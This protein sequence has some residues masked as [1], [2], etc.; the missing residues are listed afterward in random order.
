MDSSSLT[1]RCLKITYTDDHKEA[2]CVVAASSSNPR[3][4]HMLNLVKNTNFGLVG[5]RKNVFEISK[6]CIWGH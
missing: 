6:N 2:Y 4:I 5:Q 1:L 3:G